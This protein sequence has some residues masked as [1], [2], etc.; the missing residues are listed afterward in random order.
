MTTKNQLF[1]LTIM[2]A[3]ISMASSPVLTL[4]EGVYDIETPSQWEGAVLDAETGGDSLF[5]VNFNT[6]DLTVERLTL[7]SDHRPIGGTVTIVT[8]W[9]IDQTVGVV[10]GDPAVNTG[11]YSG[12]GAE[13]STIAILHL[14]LFRKPEEVEMYDSSNTWYSGGIPKIL[15][16]IE[17]Q[18]IS[19]AH[20][21]HFAYPLDPG[22]PVLEDDSGPPQWGGAWRDFSAIDDSI[23]TAI[24]QSL[25]YAGSELGAS[26]IGST[27][28]GLK[29]WAG[30]RGVHLENTIFYNNVWGEVRK[31]IIGTSVPIIEQPNH[32]TTAIG[33]FDLDGERKILTLGAKSFDP[34]WRDWVAE[35]FSSALSLQRVEC[36]Y[37]HPN[38]CET[39]ATCE[40]QAGLIWCEEKEKCYQRKCPAPFNWALFLP[41]IIAGG[42]K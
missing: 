10:I 17:Q 1:F 14:D 23:A 29:E 20:V 41:A 28:R 42:K 39:P 30:R 6:L 31:L 11:P 36:D 16:G 12:C 33:F 26:S 13:A 2:M 8:S 21:E 38:L 34:V 32:A 5:R 15:V 24:H 35:G 25:S 27:A 37:N 4:A 9:D 19:D 22:G 7:L 40:E 18:S 3:I